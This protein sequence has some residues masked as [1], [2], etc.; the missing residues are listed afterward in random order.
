VALFT[1]AVFGQLSIGIW[2]YLSL[3][4]I[5]ASCG[6]L[7]YLINRPAGPWLCVILAVF[8]LYDLDSFNWLEADKSNLNATHGEL[9]QMVSLGRPL[10]FI[11]AQ[12]GLYRTRVRVAVEPNIGDIYS[13]P[14]VWGGGATLL[15]DFAEFGMREDLL[16][17]GYLIKPAA[18][19]D[20][21]AVYQ[22]A[23]WKVYLNPNAYPRAWVVHQ[24]TFEPHHDLVFKHL[25]DPGI[26]LHRTAFIETPLRAQLDGNAGAGDSV[27][28]ISYEANRMQMDVISDANGLLVL[29]EIYYPGWR[30]YVNGKQETILRVDGALRGVM[31]PSGHSRVELRF[32]PIPVYAG[33]ALSLVAFLGVLVSALIA[34]RKGIWR[35]LSPH[36][37]W[38]VV[39]TRL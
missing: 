4:L 21:G 33:G 31:I 19:G 23:H 1:P 14:T 2:D 15:T 35:P 29:S 6:F 22:D 26:N 8:V 37:E 7:A 10:T 34:W 25:D 16:N 24:T 12:P 20:P 17:V 3:L 28:F 5:L 30:A 27:R 11:K 39:E 38:D 13:V 32:V 9:E 18:T 36:S